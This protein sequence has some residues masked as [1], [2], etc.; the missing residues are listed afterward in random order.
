MAAALFKS[1][2]R[3]KHDS[4]FAKIKSELRKKNKEKVEAEKVITEWYVVAKFESCSF[5][6]YLKLFYIYPQY[7]FAKALTK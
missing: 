1:K 7:G 2:G 5:Y 4:N 3:H 6:E